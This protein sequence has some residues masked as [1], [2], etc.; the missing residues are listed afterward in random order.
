[1]PIFGGLSR[2]VEGIDSKRDQDAI[3]VL[4]WNS[5]ENENVV[6]V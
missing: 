3:L 5:G 1:M 2:A 6:K 4:K